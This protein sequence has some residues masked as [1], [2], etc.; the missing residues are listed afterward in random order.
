MR[1][2]MCPFCWDKNVRLVSYVKTPDRTLTRELMEC[3]VCEKHYWGDTNE[4]VTGLYNLCE[5]FQLGKNGCCE[6]I[7]RT[8]GSF[9]SHYD[10]RK[11]EEWDLLCSMC[12]KRDFHLNVK[13]SLE[14]RPKN[15]Q[16]E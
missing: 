9:R 5:T 13:F 2:I 14:H 15:M 7:K 3:T 16:A 11:L 10:K 12:P 4:E 8:C 1:E 6:D